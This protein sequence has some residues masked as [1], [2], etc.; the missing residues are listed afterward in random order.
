MVASS[1]QLTLTLQMGVQ[2]IGWQVQ[3]CVL[4]ASSKWQALTEREVATC[5]HYFVKVLTSER[6]FPSL[7]QRPLVEVAVH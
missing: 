6:A 4:S 1:C 2:T 7:A 5:N 3:A